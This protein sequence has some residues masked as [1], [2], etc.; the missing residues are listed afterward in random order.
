MVHVKDEGAGIPLGCQPH[1]FDPFY[2]TDANRSRSKGGTGLGLTLV[3]S[4]VE[5]MGGEVSLQSVPGQGSVFTIRL[6]L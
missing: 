1:L 3:R 6:P 2:R 5:A 4:I